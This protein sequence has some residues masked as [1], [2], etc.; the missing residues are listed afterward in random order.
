M[1]AA[2]LERIVAALE[3]NKPARSVALNEEEAE[4]GELK[5]IFGVD[6]GKSLYQDLW[7]PW[8]PWICG[9]LFTMVLECRATVLDVKGRGM[10]LPLYCQLM[11]ELVVRPYRRQIRKFHAAVSERVSHGRLLQSRVCAC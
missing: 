2:A 10:P 5:L 4:L 8:N 6:L 7:Y 1:E 9:I 3:Q 11:T